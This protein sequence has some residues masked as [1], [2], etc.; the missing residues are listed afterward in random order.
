MAHSRVAFFFREAGYEARQGFMS[1]ITPLVFFGLTAYMLIILLSADNMRSMGAVDIYRNSPHVVYLMV[2]G[3]CL[4]LF[5]AWAWLFAQIIVR[6]R[7][8]QLHEVVLASPVSLPWLI[9]AR[10]TGALVVA[11]F[12]GSSIC[13]GLLLAP[14]LVTLG[15]LPADAVGP[16]PW[17]A[18]AWSLVVFTIPNALATGMLF[19]VAASW[20]RSN[21]GAFAAAALL[22]LVWMISLMV[23]REGDVAP[24]LASVIDPSGFAEAERQSLA[25]TPAEKKVAIIG[26]TDALLLNR[27][28]W[29]LLGAAFGTALLLRLRREHLA[30][31]RAPRSQAPKAASTAARATAPLEPIIAPIVVTHWWRALFAECAWHL[32]IS[33]Q[34][35]GLRLALL[36]LTV[37]GVVGSWVNVV[38]HSDGPLVPTPQAQLR[39]LVEF[40]FVIVV[41][42]VVGFVGALMRRDDHDGFIEWLDASPV[43]LGIRL[44]ARFFA[45]LGL[46]VLLCLV[47][48]VAS[49]VVTGLGAPQSLDAIYPFAHVLLTLFPAFAELCAIAVLAHAL[50]RRAGT[51]YVV[52][53]LA[54]FIAIINHDL[55]LVE[56]P[57]AAVVV[58]IHAYPSELTG[59]T[60]WMPMVATLV[61]WKL[62][63]VLLVFAASWIA[64]RRGTAL[65]LRDRLA[66]ARKR[67]LGGAGLTAAA[68]GV[69]LAALASVLNTRLVDEGGYESTAEALQRDGDWERDWWSQAAPFSLRGGD[70]AVRLNPSL[71]IGEVRWRIDGLRASRLHGTLPHGIALMGA[72]RNGAPADLE[73]DGDH[74]AVEAGCA[75]PCTLTLELAVEPQGWQDE[76]APWLHAS[77]VWLRAQDVLPTLGHDPDR[78]L[79]SIG[80]RARLG[81]PAELPPLPVAAALRSLEGVAP[82]GAWSWSVAIAE[83]TGDYTRD[84]VV[85]DRGSVGG[86]LAFA[87]VWLPG[88]PPEQQRMSTRFLVGKARLPLLDKFA[89]D[90]VALRQCVA[91]EFGAAPVIEAVLQAPRETGDIALYDGVLWAPED[92][93]W[94][95]DGTGSG[96]WQRQYNIAA[97]IARDAIS[98]RSDLRDEAGARWLLEGTAGWVALRCVEARSGFEAAIALRKRAAETIAEVFATIDKPV[99]QVVDADAA[100]L[101]YYAALSLD[102]WGAASG[103]TPDSMLAV[104]D[105][106]TPSTALLPR[107]A[108][109]IGPEALDALLGAPV[110]SDVS[111]ARSDAGVAATVSSW[112]W[113]AGGWQER[114]AEH[115]LL[116][117]GPDM[118]AQD[119]VPGALAELGAKLDGAYL[120]YAGHGYERSLD[121]NRLQDE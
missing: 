16:V 18:T 76:A 17:A 109:Q 59:W 37:M 120:F 54:A 101:G 13:V 99:T 97:A 103:Y 87:S 47:P 74:F 71:G 95:S 5:F 21:A 6:D 38:G 98:A 66:A 44:L 1:L 50:F 72:K 42:V 78:L 110:R 49:L 114:E 80:D 117:R 43:P 35:F 52:S 69:L 4:W 7:S 48:A 57:P 83:S 68:A 45:A 79:R 107:L 118:P 100:W 23:L 67:T 28:F 85:A 112:V 77:G 75:V 90:L 24:L 8:A 92:I 62:A 89:A 29:L 121:D 19:L 46:T 14:L 105:G 81:L 51:A 22:S 116:V 20:T 27:G 73:V 94:Q 102:N 25:W 41:F 63:L 36:L 12:L 26:F 108:L 88:A 11:V 106:D 119:Y 82:A 115:R 10:F 2:S 40:Y 86:V 60:P 84:Y 39:F 91:A 113:Q 70:V 55:E 96:A 30:L 56:Y 58:P 32:K 65:T 3:Q 34:G 104:L 15:A 33:L 61:G 31:E 53:I 64:W 93:A 9:A 111:V